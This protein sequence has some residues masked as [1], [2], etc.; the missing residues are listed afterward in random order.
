M[1]VKSLEE[2]PEVLL[3]VMGA[4]GGLGV[5]LHGENGVLP[6]PHP[7]HCAVIEVEVRNLKWFRARDAARIAPDREAVVLGS[8]K[9][10]AGLK[11]AYRM[12]SAPVTVGQLHRV[13]PEGES[14]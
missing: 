5:V 9:Y 6:V 8:D 7:F 11:I 13:A 1:T 4:G 2:L 14:K 12:V 10:L 3:S